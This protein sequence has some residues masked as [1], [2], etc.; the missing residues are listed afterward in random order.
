PEPLAGGD[1]LGLPPARCSWGLRAFSVH[2]TTETVA[3]ST[4]KFRQQALSPQVAPQAPPP[5]MISPEG[6]V[7]QLVERFPRTEEA[8]SS[9]LL[10]S[11]TKSAGQG[12]VSS[13]RPGRSGACWP[14]FGRL[15]A[16]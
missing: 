12:P 4:Q 1:R 14:S 6:A 11:T 2:W 13:E 7:A 9:N 3:V 5:T 16:R 10:R 8:G 15:A